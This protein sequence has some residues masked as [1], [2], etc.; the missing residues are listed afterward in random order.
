MR[1][2]IEREIINLAYDLVALWESPNIAG[3]PR[4][5][6]NKAIEETR[7]KMI[8]AV[9]RLEGSHAKSAPSSKPLGY[10]QAWLNK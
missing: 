8:D 7:A 9:H 5:E 1:S 3:L 2:R 4:N 10:T 6:R